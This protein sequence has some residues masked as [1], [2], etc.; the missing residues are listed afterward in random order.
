MRYSTRS[1]RQA[2]GAK[3][4][5]KEHAPA[6]ALSEVV[7]SKVQTEISPLSDKVVVIEA[8]G[9]RFAITHTPDL[10][11]QVRL[12]KDAIVTFA[13]GELDGKAVSRKLLHSIWEIKRV[14]PDAIVVSSHVA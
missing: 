3:K 7:E 1:F 6:D 8:Q 10:A 9:L 5:V 12:L 14:F 13:E 11:L 4:Y 2:I